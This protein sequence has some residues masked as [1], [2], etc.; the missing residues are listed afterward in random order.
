MQSLAIQPLFDPGPRPTLAIV[1]RPERFPVRRIY[2]VGRNYAAHAREMGGDPDREPPFFFQKPADAVVAD[3]ADVPYPPRTDDLQHEVELVVAL[4]RGGRNIPVAEAGALVF[5]QAV[6]IDLTRRDLQAAARKAGKP[7]DTA[8]A[9]DHSAPVGILHP[10]GPAGPLTR[11]RIWLAVNGDRRQQADLADMTWSVAEVIAELSTLFDLAPGDLI[12][13]GTPSGVGSLLPGDR[14]D[15][16]IDGLEP[17]VTRIVPP[18][19]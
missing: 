8:K 16:G 9:F 18:V 14:I 11:G 17:L 10:V 3:G 15:A 4:G 19:A 1:G 13:T 5:A 2:C 7:W 6:G 12:F